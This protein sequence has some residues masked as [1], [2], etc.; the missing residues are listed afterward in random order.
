[1][2]SNQIQPI[3]QQGNLPALVVALNDRLRSISTALTA[4]SVVAPSP[5]ALAPE[6]ALFVIGTLAIESDA[7]PHLYLPSA[8]TP[9]RMAAYVKQAPTGSGLTFRI[10]VGGSNWS[11]ATIPA[12]Q[13]SVI[14]QAPGSIQPATPV[15][16]SV[17]AVGTTLPGS[18]LAVFFYQ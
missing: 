18:D 8:W 5:Q 10:S 15:V 16:L 2:G 9:S 13:T 7:A 12:G 3:A 1:M 14:V 17:T 11:P 6:V 4:A